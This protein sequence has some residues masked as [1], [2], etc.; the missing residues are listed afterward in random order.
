MNYELLRTCMYVYCCKFIA[1]CVCVCDEYIYDSFN[2]ITYLIRSHSVPLG[3][4]NWHRMTQII[5]FCH[6]F[7][8][9]VYSYSPA[10]SRL[11]FSPVIVMITS[12][13][14]VVSRSSGRTSVTTPVFLSTLRWSPDTVNDT[15]VPSGSRPRR[16]YTDDP[17]TASSLTGQRNRREKKEKEIILNI[18]I[19]WKFILMGCVTRNSCLIFFAC[20]WVYVNKSSRKENISI[21]Y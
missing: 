1:A 5:P 3:W 18:H 15:A 19:R 7:S 4:H 16:V 20:L 8:L 12:I 6:Y 21:T 2:I 11:I 17:T 13:M 10:L 9:F 14:G